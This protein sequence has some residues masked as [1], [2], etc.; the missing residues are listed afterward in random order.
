LRAQLER[1][2][3]YPTGRE[4]SLMRPSGMVRVW[5]VLDR[6]G[7]LLDSGVEQSSHA[8]LLDHAALSSVRRGEYPAFPADSWP[9]DSSHRF[10]VD[11]NY[12][13]AN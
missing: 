11:L 2:K 7:R 3:R 8:M 13:P 1:S 4:A 9:G 5:L 6:S 12:T 10:T